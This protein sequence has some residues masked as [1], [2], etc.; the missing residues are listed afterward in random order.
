MDLMK[1]LGD[2]HE[3]ELPLISENDCATSIDTFSRSY[4][5]YINEWSPQ[6]GGC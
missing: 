4:H 1:L 2:N 3:M 6:V 5:E